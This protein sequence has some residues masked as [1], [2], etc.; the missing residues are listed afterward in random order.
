MEYVLE[1]LPYARSLL[2]EGQCVVELRTGRADRGPGRAGPENSNFPDGPGPGRAPEFRPGPARPGPAQ[3]G[4]FPVGRVVCRGLY[5]SCCLSL[6][7]VLGTGTRVPVLIP[8]YPD[9]LCYP[10][11]KK[12]FLWIFSK[13][14]EIVCRRRA[15]LK[16]SSVDALVFLS[17]NMPALD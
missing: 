5:A 2:T 16:P 1:A 15:S 17:K 10:N 9:P 4:S 11:S 14:G 13:A 8:G 3:P 6:C 7:L 12:F